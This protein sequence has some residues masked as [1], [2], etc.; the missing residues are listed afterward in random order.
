[1]SSST[2]GNDDIQIRGSSNVFGI[3]GSA[4]DDITVDL[5]I[6]N[7]LMGDSGS[8]H[9]G[10][11]N[12]NISKTLSVLL[13]AQTLDDTNGGNDRL[14][15]STSASTPS[16]TSYDNV[17]SRSILFGGRAS[18][19]INANGHCAIICGDDCSCKSPKSTINV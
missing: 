3:G 2:D 18:D 7:V 1:V 10:S 19:Q 4:N 15:V 6:F 11:V 9:I 13:S 16:M 8:L 12:S 14:V 17:V 5:S